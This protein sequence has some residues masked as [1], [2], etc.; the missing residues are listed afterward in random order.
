MMTDWE[1]IA[2]LKSLMEKIEDGETDDALTQICELHAETAEKIYHES[3]AKEGL[4]ELT[5][6]AG[7]G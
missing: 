3:C 7:T 2:W 5:R 6:R 1:L 4:Y